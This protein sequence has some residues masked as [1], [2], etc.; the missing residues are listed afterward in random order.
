MSTSSAS[1][2]SPPPELTPQKLR[3]LGVLSPRDVDRKIEEEVRTAFVVDGLLSAKSVAVAAGD[4][5][6][7]KSPLVLELAL[8]VAAGAPFLGMATAQGR[9]LYL[10]LENPL[11]D[12]KMMRD[13]LVRFLQLGNA[14]EDFLLMTEP[15]PDL[16]QV[17][18]EI[19]PQLVVIDSVRSFRPEATKS[20]VEA[21]NWLKGIRAQARKYGCAFLFV[22][23]LRKPDR[24]FGPPD[25]ES[26]SVVNWLLEMEGPRAFVNQTDLRIAITEGEQDVALRV[27]WS[28]RVYGDSPLV[29]LERI[30]DEEGDP[31]GYR[32]ATGAALLSQHRREALEKLPPE[33]S[34]KKAKA[35]LGRAD[36]PTNKFLLQCMQLGVIEK[37]KKGH[38]R[39][40]T[41]INGN[42]GGPRAV[43]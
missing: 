12:C 30:Y 10:D 17:I 6:I 27:K 40:L 26:N 29:L 9:V 19:R 28:R 13:A 4:S 34:F 37:V 18:A 5:A 24:S 22:H 1:I 42:A 23:H 14:P 2:G 38:Y 11:A 20:N 3:S 8:C 32:A 16:A 39:K 15:P 35:A 21:G 36:D 7:G 31:A 25:L 33:F 43:E 41:A